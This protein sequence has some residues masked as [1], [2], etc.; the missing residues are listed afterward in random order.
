MTAK[1]S[2]AE[3]FYQKLQRQYS[4]KINLN[5]SRIFAALDKFNIDPDI[6]I[7]GSIFQCIGSDGKNTL[8]QTILNIL[9][10]NKK[11]VTTF[12]SPAIISP[13]DRIFLKNKFITLKQ[14]KVMADKIISTRYKLTLFEVITLIYLL[15]I[16]KVKDIDYHIVEAGAGF[17]HDSTNVWRFPTAQLVTN[18]NLQHRE[19]FG[20]KTIKD[21]CKI[22]CE[23]LSHNTNIYIG[24]QNPKTLKIIKK[25]LDKNPSKKYFYGRDF[26]LKKRRNYYLYSDQKGALKLKAKHIYSEGLWENVALGV[27]VCRD[28]NI[29]KKVILRALPKIIL[30]GRLQ[31]IKKG[32]LRKLLHVKEDLLLDGCHSEASIK[33]HVKFLKNINKPKYAIWSLMKNREPEKYIKYLKCFKKIV[34]IKVPNE[35]NSC[36]PILL[37][38]IADKNNINCIAAP[39]IQTAIKKISSKESKCI[40]II[41]SLY[42]AGSFLNLN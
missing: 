26:K 37:K 23:A 1:I 15:T 14:F 39:N 21:I 27:K 24:K 17:N 42:T 33:N 18:I 34:V 20:V 38:K 3:K 22:K 8:V 12:T 25:I 16:K 11:K 35:K 7:N 19:L 41:G 31:F 6:N 10:E 32:K 36:S 13:L 9:K 5:R 29:D 28:L 2:Q 4:R 30:I 40:S